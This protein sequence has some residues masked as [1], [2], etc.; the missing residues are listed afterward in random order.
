[1]IIIF[2]SPLACVGGR[3]NNLI[4]KRTKRGG[5]QKHKKEIRIFIYEHLFGILKGVK[6]RKFHRS[7]NLFE[8]FL[9]VIGVFVIVVGY[10]F[11][12]NARAVDTTNYWLF[13]QTMFLWLMLTVLVILLA[14]N[15]NMK[16][17]L[18][19]IAEEQLEQIKLLARGE[20]QEVAI[21]EQELKILDK[22]K[23]KK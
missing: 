18:K 1:M 23:K 10:G 21:E 20:K 7:P 5:Q 6:M 17:E 8:K 2:L 9:L 19:I 4:F 12:T 15:E 14:V 16:E 22:L 13:L 11:I 3:E